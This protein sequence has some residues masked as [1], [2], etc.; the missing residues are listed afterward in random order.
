MDNGF[1][2]YKYSDNLF[3]TLSFKQQSAKKECAQ[4]MENYIWSLLMSRREDEFFRW[5]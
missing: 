2:Y 4:A 5:L 3:L 1:I